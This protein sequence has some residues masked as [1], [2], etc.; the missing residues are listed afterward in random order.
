[1]KKTILI[2]CSWLDLDS[3][4]GVFFI[5]Q[6]EIV[7]SEYNPILVVFRKKEY[8]LKK[9]SI[10]EKKTS[11]GITV[12]EIF[13]PQLNFFTEKINYYFQV[14][15]VKYLYKYLNNKQIK[16]LFIHSQSLFDAGIWSYIYFL[17]FNTPYI[18]T[19][20]DQLSFYN[21]SKR[22]C[23]FAKKAIQKSCFNLVV[24]NDK[25]R[26]FAA[27]G[28]MYEFTNI[29]NLINRNFFYKQKLKKESKFIKII[30]VGAFHPIKDQKTILKALDII[31]KKS[32]VKIQFTWIG[33]N[34]WGLNN[35]D[36]VQ[37]LFNQFDF[38]NIVIEL[39]P[40]LDRKSICEYLQ[41]SDL[42]VFSSISEGMPVSVLEALGCGIPVFTS[43][44]GGVDEIID[45]SN[46]KIF[47]IKDFEKL[48]ELISEFI[49]GKFSY[50]NSEISAK[51]L[52]NFGENAFKNKLLSIYNRIS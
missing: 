5:E 2:F 7:S 6:A 13:Y 29:G 47:Q 14:L 8:L 45:D 10:I 40:L 11:E 42:F 15:T 44:C 19:E 51:I 21:V 23:Y 52:S 24:S 27:N 20:H 34:G 46:G 38:E 41:N 49:D 30:T 50:N 9:I 36:Q 48:S 16:V 18:I 28:F 4:I 26:Q 25:V 32:D 43:N 17:F 39:I 3:K 1:M 35:D 33:Y 37:L 22:K 12:L 31:D